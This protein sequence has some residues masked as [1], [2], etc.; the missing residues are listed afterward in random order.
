MKEFMGTQGPWDS[1]LR[2]AIE[3]EGD[4]HIVF[5]GGDSAGNAFHI[6]YASGWTDN[7]STKQEASANAKLI[8]A[9][10]ELL[11]HLQLMVE[12]YESRARDR[13]DGTVSL[14]DMLA[15]TDGARKA[16]AKALGEKV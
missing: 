13:C 4:M 16:I 15:F 9:A 12:D 6:A 3:V 1:K 5:A 2:K 8:C 11:H 14:D 7:K 10:P